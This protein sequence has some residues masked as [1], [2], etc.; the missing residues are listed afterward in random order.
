[1]REANDNN[2]DCVIV[3]D[4]TAASDPK[5]HKSALE[6]VKMEGGIFG[7]VSSTAKIL[8]ALEGGKEGREELFVDFSGMD[9]TN[10][11]VPAKQTVFVTP[12]KTS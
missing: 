5:L 7:A 8:A 9:G 12:D 4:A 1:M 2:F 6:S 3:E 11:S 10:S